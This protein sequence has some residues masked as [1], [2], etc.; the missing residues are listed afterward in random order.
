VFDMIVIFYLAVYMLQI[1]IFQNW[2]IISS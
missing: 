2:V 1:L